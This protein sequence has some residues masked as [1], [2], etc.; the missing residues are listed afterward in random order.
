MPAEK[1]GPVV[2]ITALALAGAVNLLFLSLWV[3]SRAHV[4]PEAMVTAMIWMTT[5][6]PIPALPRPPGQEP[7]APSR[8]RTPLPIPPATEPGP[9]QSTAIT[10]APID[11][12]AEGQRSARNAYKDDVR[13]KPEPSLHSKPQAL[14]LPDRSNQPHKLGDSEHREGGEIITWINETCFYSYKPAESMYVGP[15]RLKLPICKTRSM[16]ARRSEA[17]A[18]ELEKDAKP[19]YLSRPL[20]AV[21]DVAPAPEVETARD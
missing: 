14:V 7:R 16:A 18:A 21:P 11:W 5:P 13:E 20:P 9:T 1:R 4:S 3:F 15:P 19:D 12:Y 8:V 6:L 2:R 10:V 17:M